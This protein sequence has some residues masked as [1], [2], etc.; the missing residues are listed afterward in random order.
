MS[1][2]KFYEVT[3]DCGHK[4]P[5]S[6]AEI[7][8]GN[9]SLEV[10]Q[11]V[12]DRS[13]HWTTCPGCNEEFYVHKDFIYLD[14]EK[15]FLFRVVPSFVDRSFEEVQDD[16]TK[17][18][19]SMANDPS[20]FSLDNYAI[21]T[22]SRIERLREKLV[23]SDNNLDDDQM[24]ALKVYLLQRMLDRENR[25]WNSPDIYLD[26]VTEKSLV[27]RIFDQD[28]KEL[29]ELEIDKS[30]L[31]EIS[32]IYQQQKEVEFGAL[33]EDDITM[34]GQREAL[35]SLR[36]YASLHP[37]GPIDTN[38]ERF[39]RMLNFIPRGNRIS[40][41]AKRYLYKVCEILDN[42]PVDKRRSIEK[43]FEIRF[44]VDLG[45]G[46]YKSHHTHIWKLW[47]ALKTLP[48]KH[49]EQNSEIKQ[50]VLDTK[51]HR[52]GGTYNSGTG[53]I[54]IGDT[55]ASTGSKT[56][57]DKTVRHEIGHAVEDQRTKLVKGWQKNVAGWKLYS[58]SKPNIKK[59]I[60]EMGGYGTKVKLTDTDKKDI[61]DYIDSLLVKP[62]PASWLPDSSIPAPRIKFAGR[63]NVINS[64]P[65]QAVMGCTDFTPPHQRWYQLNSSWVVYGGKA[66]SLNYWYSQLMVVDAKQLRSLMAF[67]PSSY[68]AMSP[69]EFF[70]EV[71]AY[72][73]DP[74]Y[75]TGSAVPKSIK[76]WFEKNL[77]RS[78][79][80][81][82]AS[83]MVAK[84]RDK[85]PIGASLF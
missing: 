14:S 69:G 79:G 72:F 66:F 51:D 83:I 32:E 2:F 19:E 37:K 50:I 81:S 21:R 75:P 40:D 57:F 43:L 53:I 35:K 52:N 34:F 27:F 3:C 42:F 8:H 65:I 55:L 67:L 15:E 30:L 1:Q 48:D 62:T 70:A 78:E 47:A 54:A 39:R 6:L 82:G 29:F 44:N 18:M 22:V 31:K 46:W 5:V 56:F 16:F 41:D 84:S 33:Q 25:T 20:K 61:L 64:R 45:S 28:S 10:K 59:W 17:M 26:Q 7:I 74:K 71:Y 73:Y 85:R 38:S 9:R 49:V 60:A 11:M 13:L 80:P 36:H 76:T 68:A 12:Y 4:H 24:D 58:R 23:L 77:G 63:P